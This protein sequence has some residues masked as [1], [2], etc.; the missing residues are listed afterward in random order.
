MH[1]PKHRACRSAGVRAFERSRPNGKRRGPVG[2]HAA[3]RLAIGQGEKPLNDKGK[4]SF[5]KPEIDL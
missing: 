3:D 4:L 2:R 1:E 5:R